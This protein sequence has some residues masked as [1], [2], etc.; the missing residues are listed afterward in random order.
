MET[1]IAWGQ[2]EEGERILD[3]YEL[4]GQNYRRARLASVYHAHGHTALAYKQLEQA[5]AMIQERSQRVS[6]ADIFEVYSLQSIS[7]NVARV[8]A[9]IG[10]AARALE[11]AQSVPEEYQTRVLCEILEQRLQEKSRMQARIRVYREVFE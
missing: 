7:M 3:A 4:W 2:P 1:Y 6:S 8:Y 11:V 10:D 9:Q 5:L